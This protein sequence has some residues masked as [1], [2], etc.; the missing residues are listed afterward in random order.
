[1]RI[2][3]W[4]SDVCSSDLVPIAN[5]LNREPIWVGILEGDTGSCRPN[6][7]APVMSLIS[8]SNGARERMNVTWMSKH[9]FKARPQPTAFRIVISPA[10][11]NGGPAHSPG[12]RNGLESTDRQRVVSGKRFYNC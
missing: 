2:S 5:P 9:G 10:K 4:S 11:I 12:E 7:P 1:M 6:C 3:D 8:P